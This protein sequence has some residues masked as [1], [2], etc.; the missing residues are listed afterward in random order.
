MP[1]LFVYIVFW[2]SK[3]LKMYRLYYTIIIIYSTRD[4]LSIDIFQRFLN[5]LAIKS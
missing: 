3:V 5:V 4:T 1:K 2:I